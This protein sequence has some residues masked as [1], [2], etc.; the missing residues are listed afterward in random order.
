MSGHCRNPVCNAELD[1]TKRSR[2]TPRRFCDH[3]CRLT[4]WILKR[5]ARLLAPLEQA[6]GW[7]ILLKLS[8]EGS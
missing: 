5:A 4:R 7:E 8:R 2:G 6:R 1:Q 3:K